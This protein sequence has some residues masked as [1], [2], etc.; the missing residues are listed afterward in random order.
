MYVHPGIINAGKDESG[1]ILTMND[2]QMEIASAAAALVVDEGMDYGQA[3][4][5]ALKALGLPPHTALPDNLAVEEAVRE[6]LA[7]F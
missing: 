2:L 4:V 1:R 6:H 3:K 5:R 7:L